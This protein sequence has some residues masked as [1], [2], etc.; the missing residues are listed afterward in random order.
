MIGINIVCVGNLK[1]KYWVDAIKEY[2]K[3]LGAFAKVNIVEVKE[4][5]YGTSEKE[6]L[7][8]KKSEAERLSKH[9]KGYCVALE[10]GGKNFDS[11]QFASHIESLATTGNSTI[12]FFIGGSFGLDKNFSDDCNE[13][14]SFSKFTFPHQLMRVILLE[15]IYRAFTI[16]NGK[17]YHK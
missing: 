10:I 17:T 4:S 7:D 3:R 14:L 16:I 12:S 13:K 9:K 2:E 11:E 5:E 8:A 6:I 15:Q 1:E